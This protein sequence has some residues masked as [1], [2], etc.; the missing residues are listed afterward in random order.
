[1]SMQFDTEKFEASMKAYHTPLAKHDC[2][3]YGCLTGTIGNRHDFQEVWDDFQ[4]TPKQ[5]EDIY[6][7]IVRAN[8]N[9]AKQRTII[10]PF[11]ST[12]DGSY[13][14]RLSTVG[15]YRTSRIGDISFDTQ[16][17]CYEYYNYCLSLFK[18]GTELRAT[19]QKDSEFVIFHDDLTDDG[20]FF[21]ELFAI[22]PDDGEVD[23]DEWV[24]D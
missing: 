1:M 11:I 2:T 13:V 8:G 16:S 19:I 17:K 5:R 12:K 22:D 24:W 10:R 23:V 7:D 3:A 15:N 9:P 4:L 14:L 18:F 6:M 21:D 20:G